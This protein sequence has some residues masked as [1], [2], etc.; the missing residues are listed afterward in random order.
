MMIVRLVF[1]SLLA[2]YVA[3]APVAAQVP[4]ALEHAI[5]PPPVGVQ[6]GAKL[7]FNVAADGDYFV[8]G[9]PYDDTGGGDAGV[10]KVFDAVTGVLL[11][12]IPNPAPGASDNFGLSVGVSG[13][14][15]VVSAPADDT[16]A[17]DC[18]TVYVYDL[19]SAS[20]T[21]PV[22]TLNNPTPAQSDNFG[23]AIAISGARVVVGGV[24]DDTVA[25]NSGS[26][27][28]YDLS[29]TS[30]ATPVFTLKKV[31]PVASDFFGVSVAI[32]GTRVVVGAHSD[33]TG[34]TNA[35]AAFVFDLGG[36]TPTVPVAKLE[37]PA[38]AVDD[39][40]GWSVAISGT[41]VAVGAHLDD[42]VLNG[43]VVTSAGSVYVYDLAGAT[44]TQ[45][46]ATLHK[47][48][49][50]AADQFGY[51]VAISASHVIVGTYADDEGAVDSGRAYVFEL[52]SATP[53][54]PTAT[55]NNPSPAFDDRFG[56]S[57]A[58]VGT[59][60]V[61][62]AY[63]DDTLA[64]DSGIA[65]GYDLG[66]GT[67]DVPATTLKDSGP[68]K[69]DQFGYSVAVSGT[70]VV[71]GARVED[72]GAKDSGS[73]YVYTLDGASPTET[74]VVLNNP[75]PAAED[76]FGE[77]VSISGNRVVIGAVR[78][79]TNAP[80]TGSAYVYDLG[81][82]SPSEPALILNNPNPAAGDNFGHSVSIDGPLVAVGVPQKD[83]TERNPSVSDAG[84]VYIYDL[85]S[86]TPTTPV[87]TLP[88]PFPTAADK[89]GTSVA[90]SGTRLVVGAPHEN[91][92]ASAAGRAYVYDLAP[93]AP[94][95][96]V[97]TLNN[98]SPTA[99]ENFGFSVAISGNRVVVGAFKDDAG[100]LDTGTAYVFQLGTSAVL[101]ATLNNPNPGANDAFGSS[102]AISGHRVIVGAV[103][104]DAGAGD[105]GGAYVYDLSSAT[106][107]TPIAP[108]SKPT[109]ATGDRFGCAVAIEG[110]TVVVGALSD[111]RA[112]V[113]KGFV[114]VFG[115]DLAAPEG[116]T[117]TFSPNSPV[118][119]GATVTGTF[120][121]WTDASHPLKYSLRKGSTELVPPGTS[122]A[123]TFTLT[124]GTHVIYG[125]VTDIAGNFADTA[126]TTIVA[127]GTAP[128]ITLGN[129][130]PRVLI[131]GAALP[132]YAAEA[133]VTDALGVASVTQLPPAGTVVTFPFA[134][135]VKVVAVDVAGNTSNAIVPVT[136]RP[137]GTI[138][139][140]LVQ[141][142]S[143]VPKGGTD[144]RIQVGAVWTTLGAPAISDTGAFAFLGKWKA[145]ATG[146]LP[147]Q[148]G[149]GVFVN[150][151]LLVKVGQ[152]V[153]GAG[154]GGLPANATFKSLKDPV[155]DQGGHVAF[156]ASITGTG[157]NGGNDGVVMSNGRTGTLEVIAREGGSA[158][159]TEGATFKS[160]T[161]VSMQGTTVGAALF[162]ASIGGVSGGVRVTSANNSGAWWMPAGENSVTKLVRKGDP[163][164]LAGETIKSVQVLQAISGS[165]GH[166]RGQSGP[167]RAIIQ[168]SLSGGPQPRQVLAAVVPGALT[169]LAGTGDPLGGT[170]L[171]AATW[172]TMNLPSSSSD[173]VRIA[174]LGTLTPDIGEVTKTTAK[175]VMKSADSG[176]TWEPLARLGAPAEGLDPN[177]VFSMIWDPVSSS[178][179]VAFLAAVKGGNVKAS[180]NDAIWWKPNNGALAPLARE[181]GQ[182]P[183]APNGAKWKSFSSLAL[184]DGDTGPI[185]TASLK[186]GPTA[187]FERITAN[188][189]FGLYALDSFGTL[190]EML[191]EGQIIERKIVKTFS[192]MKAISGSAGVTRSFNDTH[193][194]AALVTF[195]DR[196]TAI[197]KIEIP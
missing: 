88:H 112:M 29:G 17:L 140:V 41:R 160:F 138:R 83:D 137:S 71:V 61:V 8:V 110:T 60:A 176:A 122:S 178:S 24:Q 139:T 92:G 162:T 36:A 91:T 186:T 184:P 32:S 183:G 107:T 39:N 12:V 34:A 123:P 144:N 64:D 141:N 16:A 20:P 161:N 168:L 177:A 101:S 118:K 114:Y 38:P 130:A 56:W 94:T 3:T 166:G 150:D 65:Y 57:V 148:L 147:T 128:V 86:G 79:D 33:D 108:L 96:P 50:T 53:T 193:Q 97:A 42:P 82:G 175:G 111:D 146:Q 136:V 76:N 120:S 151:T 182:P 99:N 163:G 81:S 158:A 133:T 191:R 185:F 69:E 102:V 49:S 44:P 54:I 116:G 135:Q 2:L 104:D 84:C 126:E 197:L 113:D 48:D 192:V 132:D 127:D 14:R 26:A 143:A 6:A 58:I 1:S 23:H 77:S 78:D 10:V 43:S 106:P 80:N 93:G 13:T 157:V 121:A 142:G 35:G 119:A 70:R 4:S 181:G 75:A 52:G 5:P 154:S 11:H 100:A 46:T 155:M 62:G 179:G 172:K 74:I 173:G 115:P 195:T 124:E 89:F 95:G 145:L 37:N 164:F 87:R 174:V 45:P 109:P 167:G 134:T 9:A 189:D 90:I 129:T 103:T 66:G 190:R 7:G 188:N 19:A 15:V 31:T 98:P 68:G 85:T 105:A 30:P 59:R 152:A 47:L 22:V 156:I 187:T 25:T 21:V 28:V 171:P 72:T 63:Q 180:D 194:V 73:A 196:T 117:L 149:T 40:F 67:P 27:Y 170:E 125:R 51:S 153:P 131:S 165:T 18:G 159:G 169:D 55:L